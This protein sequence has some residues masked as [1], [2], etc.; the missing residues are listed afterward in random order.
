[1]DLEEVIGVFM[2]TFWKRFKK[3]RAWSRGKE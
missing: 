1:M 2:L 3:H